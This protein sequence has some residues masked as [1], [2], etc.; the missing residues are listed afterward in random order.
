M[1]RAFP[2]NARTPRREGLR[3]RRLAWLAAV[4]K[5]SI[6]ISRQIT[7]EALPQA[8]SEQPGLEVQRCFLHT[9]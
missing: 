3:Q 1:R 8:L 5:I 7:H 4:E 6:E 2:G 9:E